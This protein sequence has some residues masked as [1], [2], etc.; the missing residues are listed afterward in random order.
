MGL[1]MEKID[2]LRAAAD[3][4]SLESKTINTDGMLADAALA[5]LNDLL[6]PGADPDKHQAA[7]ISA[8]VVA[9]LKAESATR[10][11]ALHDDAMAKLKAELQSPRYAGKSPEE[12]LVLLC[13]EEV[14]TEE[15][16]A[17]PPRDAAVRA[18]LGGFAV[19][20]GLI[21]T[22][23]GQ[24]LSDHP[25]VQAL[26]DD[27]IKAAGSADKVPVVVETKPAPIARIW[28]GIPYCANAPTAEQITE[29]L[30]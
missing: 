17:P 16:D 12:A 15:R 30:S 23:D 6:P 24:V 14:V 1:S 26:I 28:A 18:V 21:V 27:A 19:A 13:S 29:A 5:A 9:R 4:L 3:D 11:A 8:P 20:N 2:G 7:V 22:N 25:K 10:A